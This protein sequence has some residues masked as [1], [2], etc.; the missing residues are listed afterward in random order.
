[1]PSADR[2]FFLH[3]LLRAAGGR[4][5]QGVDSAW[6]T[7]CVN[8]WVVPGSAPVEITGW[9]LGGTAGLAAAAQKNEKHALALQV[10]RPVRTAW[11]HGNAWYQFIGANML[12]LTA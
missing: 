5:A 7:S 10:W 9:N 1:M 8:A 2:A 4:D 12:D 6:R 11:L 3:V